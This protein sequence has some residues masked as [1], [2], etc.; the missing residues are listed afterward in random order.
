MYK[1][2]F[3]LGYGIRDEIQ[4]IRQTGFAQKVLFAQKVGI[5]HKMS[6]CTQS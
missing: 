2:H 3:R 1:K 4:T 6:A 5:L